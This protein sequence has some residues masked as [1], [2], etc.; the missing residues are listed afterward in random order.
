MVSISSIIEIMESAILVLIS[1]S[2][3]E[4]KDTSKKEQLAIL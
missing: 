2:A 3:D 1:D 4:S